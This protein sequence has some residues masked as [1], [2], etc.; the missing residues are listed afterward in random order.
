[1]S[2]NG[3]FRTGN[4]YMPGSRFIDGVETGEDIEPE[5]QEQETILSNINCDVLTCSQIEVDESILCNG[6]V[7]AALSQLDSLNFGHFKLN[8]NI[9]SIDSTKNNSMILKID[10]I[11]QGLIKIEGNV[12]MKNT[13]D[14]TTSFFKADYNNIELNGSTKITG[15]TVV[16]GDFKVINGSATEIKTLD[17]IIKDNIITISNNFD[18][19]TYNSNS[20]V[21]RGLNIKLEDSDNTNL[22]K[23]VGLFFTSSITSINNRS[24]RFSLVYSSIDGFKTS[25]NEA[26]TDGITSDINFRNHVGLNLK[27]INFFNSQSTIANITSYVEEAHTNFNGLLFKT[28][29]NSN[30]YGI[31][32]IRGTYLKLFNQNSINQPIEIYSDSNNNNYRNLI[33]KTYEN[34][35]LGYFKL[36]GTKI[37]MDSTSNFN[38][39]P[40]ILE[41]LNGNFIFTS[42]DNTNDGFIRFSGS[43]ISIDSENTFNRP[44]KM[45]LGSS[46]NQKGNLL[47]ETYGDNTDDNTKGIYEFRGLDTFLNNKV[48]F[49]K[50]KS[51]NNTFEDGVELST[52]FSIAGNNTEKSII[53]TSYG[54]YFTNSADKKYQK[55]VFRGNMIQFSNINGAFPTGG[56]DSDSSEKRV[57]IRHGDTEGQIVLGHNVK[58]LGKLENDGD[59]NVSGNFSANGFRTSSLNT[60]TVTIEDENIQVNYVDV[61]LV[62]SMIM[63]NNTLGNTVSSSTDEI[64]LSFNVP[65]KV[66]DLV[67]IQYSNILS[68]KENNITSLETN[69]GGGQLN[70]FDSSLT[71]PSL[72]SLTLSHSNIKTTAIAGTWTHDANDTLLGNYIWTVSIGHNLEVNDR[73]KFTQIGG[74]LT[75]YNSTDIYYVVEVLTNNK[76]RLAN[77]ING[78]PIIELNDSNNNPNTWVASKIIGDNVWDSTGNHGLN[79]KDTVRFATVNNLANYNNTTDYYVINVISDTSFQLSATNT[80][81]VISENNSST[82]NTANK[83][84]GEKYWVTSTNPNLTV[85]NLVRFTSIGNNLNTYTINTDYYVVNVNSYT[86]INGNTTYYFK[87]S[88][89]LGGSFVNETKSST[90]VSTANKKFKKL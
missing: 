79:L 28:G 47:I 20:A 31:L 9:L 67:Y 57:L 65:Y 72:G 40:T 15:S 22:D 19:S 77:S 90:S 26:N 80:G 18:D 58:I 71:T 42:R 39:N 34:S 69:I 24:N 88:T 87:L 82:N 43:E 36:N 30:N 89:V 59:L 66:N 53:F 52:E 55:I 64:I 11:T 10:D 37:V 60:K 81:S 13:E 75:N 84:V 33:F 46:T 4:R 21:T 76:L 44:V 38:T 74:N 16:D 1:M 78:N 27:D 70:Y 68:S 48:F 54:D 86:D 56:S 83:I 23:S 49:K 50:P 6:I 25:N 61:C 35:N 5:A 63:V 3:G 17:V 7:T 85:N 51:T 14:N 2:L 29:N 12:E 62:E 41:S 8:D 32:E 73:I 45:Y